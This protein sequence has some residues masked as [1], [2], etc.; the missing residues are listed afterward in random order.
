MTMANC[1]GCKAGAAPWALLAS[2]AS[3]RQNEIRNGVPGKNTRAIDQN[4]RLQA[5]LG[6]N[7]YSLENSPESVTKKNGGRGLRF[8]VHATA[9]T[10]AACGGAP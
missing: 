6:A 8:F 4:G 7:N 1:D 9:I 5:A 10:P 3:D 2:N